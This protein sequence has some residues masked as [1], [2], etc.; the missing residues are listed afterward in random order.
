VAIGVDDLDVDDLVKAIAVA[1]VGQ[2]PFCRQPDTMRASTNRESYDV[3]TS[4]L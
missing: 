1:F 4:L 3:V 2:D